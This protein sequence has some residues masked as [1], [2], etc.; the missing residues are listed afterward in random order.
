MLEEEEL[1]FPSRCQPFPTATHPNS[2]IHNRNLQTIQA[3]NNE[4]NLKQAYSEILL[5]VFFFFCTVFKKYSLNQPAFSQL[6]LQFPYLGYANK[7]RLAE[8][9]GKKRKT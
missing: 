1:P 6:R 7:G 4:S 5:R 2:T 8:L 3:L 9:P